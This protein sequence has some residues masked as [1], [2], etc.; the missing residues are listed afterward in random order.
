ML[1]QISEVNITPIKA[2]DGLVAFA[3]CVVDGQLFLGSIGV[4]KRL[5]GTGYRVTYPTKRI[6]SHELNYYH[7]LTKE[8]GTAIQ[9]AVNARCIELFEKSDDADDRYNQT[10]VEHS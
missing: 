3:T 5:D 9:E 1:M 10:S 7:P 6:G 4:H 8:A 2:V